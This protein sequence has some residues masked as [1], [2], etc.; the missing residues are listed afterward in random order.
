[1]LRQLGLKAEGLY[2]MRQQDFSMALAIRKLPLGSKTSLV[3][4]IY[5]SQL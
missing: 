3:L 1:M 4:Q 2:R 5:F